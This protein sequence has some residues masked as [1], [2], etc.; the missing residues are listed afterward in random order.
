[1]D[2]ALNISHWGETARKRRSSFIVL[3]I[4]A[5]VIGTFLRV[6]LLVIYPVITLFILAFYNF[7]ITSSFILL[8]LAALIPFALSLFENIFF[9]YK[10]LSLFYMLPFLLL[11]FCNPGTEKN[12]RVNHLSVFITCLTL[13][14][15]VNDIIGIIQVLIYPSSD[16]SFVGVYSQYSLS[17]NG[18]M[19]LN[20]VLFFYYFVSF[21]A[22][23]KMLYLVPAIFFLCCSFLGYYGAGLIIFIVAF[24]L[25]FF[26]F[27]ITAIVRTTT[28]AL[29]SLTF[30]YLFMYTVKPLVLEYNIANIKKLVA[31]E[32]ERGA[33]KIT[34]FYNYGISYPRNARDFLFGSGPGTFNSRSAFM[35]GSPTY[36][37]TFPFIKDEDQPYYFKNYA[38][39]LWNAGNTQK[40]LFLDGFRNQPFSSVLAFLG[41]YGLIFTLLFF[42]LYYRYYRQVAN[43]YR[44]QKKNISLTAYFRF[45]KFLVILLPLLLLIDNYYEY[46][47]IMLLVIIGI[48]FAHAEI[49]QQKWIQA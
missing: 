8:L 7:R 30:A 42:S 44:Q 2:V 4:L 6:S 46:P 31:F 34:S 38:Y 5:L 21:L 10:L 1:M 14:A 15:L 19:L 35:V 40:E 3:I 27:R 18:L 17:I 45:F 49:E 9:K 11:L 24:I 41:E 22:H 26:K 29:V 32:P 13:V 16:D 33:R 25:T 28:I 47:E 23:R 43:T 48:K 36:F 37:Q 12:G 39:T 20:S